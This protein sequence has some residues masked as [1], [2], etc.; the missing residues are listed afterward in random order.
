MYEITEEDKQPILAF[1]ERDTYFFIDEC[2][3][4]MWRMNHEMA[5][6]RIPQEHHAGIQEDIN[7]I[8]I[9]QKF[10]VDNLSRFGVDPE[11][12]TDRK[13]SYWKWYGFWDT[14]KKGLSDEDWNKVN[15]LMEQQQPIDEY[16]PK[17]TWQ[18]FVIPE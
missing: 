13:G 17:G 6:G 12:V 8:R 2:G 9:L 3:A 4:F 16:L 14:W 7:K 11:S 18:D 10:A 1:N 5:H 15:D